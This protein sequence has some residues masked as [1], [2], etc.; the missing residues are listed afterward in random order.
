MRNVINVHTTGSGGRTTIGTLGTNLSVSLNKGTFKGGLGG[1]CRRNLVAVTSLSETING[2]LHLGFRVNLF[3]GPCISPRLTGGLIRSGRRGRL[4]QRMTHRKMILL[5][6]RKILPLDGRVKRLTIVNPGTSRVCGRLNSCA[7]PRIH[8]RITAIL[9]NV[10]TTMS[11]DAQMACM[12]K[13]TIHSAATASV[14]TTI[15]TTRGTSTMIL[16]I[17]NSDTHSF[18]AGCVD[19]NTTA[20]SRSTGALP[21]VS[22][23]RKFSHDSLHLLNSRRGLVDTITSAKGPLIIICVRKHA[24]GV[25]LTTRGTRTLLA[26]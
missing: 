20:I 24:V 3:R 6:G 12:G 9:S 10:H 7:T 18:G 13:Y 22:Y 26:T 21:S 4:T 2:M 15:T 25:G 16:M 5:G 23:K 1:T 11:R 19:A 17:N 8:R 14:P